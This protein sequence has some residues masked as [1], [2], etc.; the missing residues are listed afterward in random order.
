MAGAP[1]LWATRSCLY[2]YISL[3]PK[4]TSS[5]KSC[6]PWWAVTLEYSCPLPAQGLV[7][8]CSDQS[9]KSHPYP[10]REWEWMR[11]NHHKTK[12][13]SVRNVLQLSTIHISKK[14][15]PTVLHS[16]KKQL[17]SIHS[18]QLSTVPKNNCQQSAVP[19][20]SCQL[21]TVPK[22]NS[23]LSTVPK[24]IVNYPLFQKQAC[25]VLYPASIMGNSAI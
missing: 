7:S 23:Q 15:L 14:Q 9:T 20:N 5:P 18:C 11:T 17:L 10:H 6:M 25:I 24:A 1:Q 13:I 19:K 3:L 4:H 16:S 21:S 2:K 12:A 22:N 8:I